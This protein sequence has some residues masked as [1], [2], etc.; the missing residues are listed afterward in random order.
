MVKQCLKFLDAFSFSLK[1]QMMCLG[2]KGNKITMS[3]IRFNSIEMM[4]MPIRG[5]GFSISFFPYYNV[6]PDISPS[7]SSGVFWFLYENISPLHHAPTPPIRIMF[8]L[9]PIGVFLAMLGIRV[10]KSTTNLASGVMFVPP[11]AC[12]LS[13]FLFSLFYQC[14]IHIIMLSHFRQGVKWRYKLVVDRDYLAER[15][16]DVYGVKP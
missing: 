11:L 15:L 8:P 13:C 12:S 10:N 5:Q 4:N 3:I 16:P 9:K 14:I 2:R 6:F 1:H 7:V